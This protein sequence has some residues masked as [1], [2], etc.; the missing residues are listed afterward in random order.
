MLLIDYY[1]KK[2]NTKDCIASIERF[3][4]EKI[5][6]SDSDLH[7]LEKIYFDIDNIENFATMILKSQKIT[8][9]MSSLH[10]ILLIIMSA[11]V[12]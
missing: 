2:N 1:Y 12:D 10:Y 6:K 5:A 7:N 3:I 9:K 4:N 8:R 11:K